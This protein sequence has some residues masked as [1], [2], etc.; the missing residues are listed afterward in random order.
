MKKKKKLGPITIMFIIM[1]VVMVITSLLSLIGFDGQEAIIVNGK[2][3]THLVTINNIFSLDGINYLFQNVLTNIKTYQP[4]FFLIISLIAVG[5]LEKS[6]LLK[7][8]SLPFKKLRFK[9]LTMLVLIVSVI[10]IYIGDFSY[11]F[12]IPL[13]AVIYKCIGKNPILG[14]LTAFCGLT[15]SYGINFFYNSYSLGILTQISAR[16]DVDATYNF[17][18]LSTLYISIF[19]ALVLVI[20]CADIIDK[21]IAPKFNNPA[22]E[23]DELIVS[24]EASQYTFITFLSIL[25]VIIYFIIPSPYSGYL[26]DSNETNYIAKL[27][28]SNSPFGQGLPYIILLT[29]MICGFVYGKITKNIKS[30]FDY[31]DGLSKAFEKTG[32]VFVLMFFI[33]QLIGLV[34]WTNVG[35]VISANILDF[36]SRLEFSGLPLIVIS[37]IFII[38]IT[39]FI[40][41]TIDKWVLFSPIIIPLFMRSNITPEFTQFMFGIA[42][43]VGKMLTPLFPYYVIALSFIYKYRDK[44]SLS[45]FGMVKILLPITLIMAGIYLLVIIS[46]FLIGLPLGINILPSL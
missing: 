2:L 8:L 32:Y 37:F 34:N 40:P 3:E 45:L 44:T 6:G 22:I 19:A 20:T 41:S 21:K 31:N 1:G 18:L 13:V 7:A 23:E 26:L 42:D 38:L 35:T 24:K 43:S 30:S 17:N 39:L 4:L 10:S 5:V 36:M 28:S 46:W 16:V 25:A 12:L 14:I 11:A 29:S 9:Y 33:S 27:F 15:L